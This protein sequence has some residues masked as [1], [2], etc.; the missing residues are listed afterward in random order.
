[1]IGS[2]R[3]DA[4][5]KFSANVTNSAYFPNV[6][7]ICIIIIIYSIL[8]LQEEVS[9]ILSMKGTASRSTNITLPTIDTS[10]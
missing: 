2:I 5:T 7:L 6:A 3:I 1:M 10:V 4:A 8:F 9:D